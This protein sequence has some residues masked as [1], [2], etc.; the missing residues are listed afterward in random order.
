MDNHEEEIKPAVAQSR[1]EGASSNAGLEVAEP[2]PTHYCTFCGKG[3]IEA[4]Y[5][6]AG[7]AGCICDECVDICS[8]VI[9]Q[10]RKKREETSNV[11]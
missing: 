3:N 8:E 5:M 7:D 4:Q 11:E 9:K 10:E 2:K 6:I 1:A